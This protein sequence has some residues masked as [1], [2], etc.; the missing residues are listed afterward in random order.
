MQVCPPQ[1]QR[2]RLVHNGSAAAKP[3]KLCRPCGYQLTRPTPR[4]KPLA[5][6]VHAVLLY[7]SG[8]SMH[9]IA[10][11]LRVSVQ[12]A[13]TWRRTFAQEHDEKPERHCQL[14]R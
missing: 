12:S 14:N 1:C 7:L 5:M 3:K 10:F 9:R 4:G 2:D 8:L 11:L 13:L 6:Q